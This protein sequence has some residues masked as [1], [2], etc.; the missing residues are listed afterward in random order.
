MDVLA[1]VGGVLLIILGVIGLVVPLMPGIILIIVG[2]AVLKG[3]DIGE[4]FGNLKKKIFGK[5]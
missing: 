2:V 5:R 4:A 1:K 3:E